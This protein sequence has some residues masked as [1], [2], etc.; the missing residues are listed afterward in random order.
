MERF[1]ILGKSASSKFLSIGR[2]HFRY[3]LNESFR[4][5]RLFEPEN[6]TNSHLESILHS[7]STAQRVFVLQR[8]VGSFSSYQ[9][10]FWIQR[11]LHLAALQ[12]LVDSPKFL[13]AFLL[14]IF[15]FLMRFKTIAQHTIWGGLVIRSFLDILNQT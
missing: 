5:T 3:F 8:L 14:D 2:W 13:W 11:S 12:F 10:A 1:M 7:G 15:F 9:T 4:F 6:K